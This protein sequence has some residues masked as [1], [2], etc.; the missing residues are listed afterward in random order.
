MWM[1]EL[2]MKTITAESRMGSHKVVSGTMIPPYVRRKC[3]RWGSVARAATPV[4]LL[5]VR[6]RTSLYCFATNT[7]NGDCGGTTVIPCVTTLPPAENCSRYSP[8]TSGENS[9]S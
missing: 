6:L 7:L 8:G 5:E 2:A 9:K 3:D 1:I 4:Y